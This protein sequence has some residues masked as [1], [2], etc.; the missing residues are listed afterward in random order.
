MENDSNPPT[1]LP[2]R[3][4]CAPSLMRHALHAC[5]DTESVKGIISTD[6]VEKMSTSLPTEM[7]EVIHF[8]RHL[9]TSITTLSEVKGFKLD[10]ILTFFLM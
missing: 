9:F 5:S 2:S 10:Q 7:I 6:R 3:S 8:W 1:I 4:K